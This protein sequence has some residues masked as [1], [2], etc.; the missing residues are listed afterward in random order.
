M[1][2]RC[3][4]QLSFTTS[5]RHV[6]DDGTNEYKIIML[7]KRYLSFRVIK[8]NKECVRGLWAGQ[9]QELVF[10]RNRNPERGS[11][12]N[13][14]QALR[15]MINSSCDQPIGYP[16]YVSPLTTS[17][18]DSHDQL[19]EIVGGPISVANIRNFIVSTWHRLRK[20]CG[21][22]CNSGGNIEDSDAGGGTSI[23]SN[24]PSNANDAQISVSQGGVP[25]GTGHVQ[26]T[27]R[28]QPPG[29]PHL[30]TLGTSH[31]S[32]SMQSS[33]VRH[34]PARGSVASQSSYCY[35]SRHSSLRTSNT[36]FVPCRRSST[37]QIS[38]RN[39]PTSIQSRLS[40][41]NQADPTSQSVVIGLPSSSSS[42][43]SIPACKR[44]TLVGFLGTEGGNN[45]IETQSCGNS[46]PATHSRAKK[47]DVMYR[48]QIV[49]PSQVL[50][51]V[52]I[53]K[54]KELQWPDELVRLKAGKNSWKDWIPQEGMEGHVIHRWVPCSRDPCNRSHIDKTILLIKIE[55][56]Y[57]A[58]IET[59]VLEL[60]AEV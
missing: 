9:Q 41:A 23:N 34:S 6:M 43:Q 19:K 27:S 2:K 44:H 39:L 56:K 20:G 4:L 13:A 60:G 33:L 17:Y 11:I 26:A 32:H 12:Q 7:N 53:S 45:L 28:L 48:V 51:G 24:I 35:N 3:S 18:S 16:I 50:E 59:G 22:G 40:M 1:E 15:N 21:A 25:G 29:V 30:S 36:G 54:R 14:K 46:S 8:V 5:L 42:S 57:V 52:N 10:L 31:S 38:L 37:S 49:D 47:E 58:V 55:D